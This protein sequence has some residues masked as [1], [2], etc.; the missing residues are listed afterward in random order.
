[1]RRLVLLINSTAKETKQ[2]PAQISEAK[3]PQT[4]TEGNNQ[5]NQV[6]NC[7]KPLQ[8][9]AQLEVLDFT[10]LYNFPFP[11]NP[12]RCFIIQNLS[13]S[14]AFRPGILPAIKSHLQISPIL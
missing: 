10:S 8:V 9:N 11:A 1:M 12:S 2:N 6:K 3:Q 13:I 14:S 5:Q 4:N 7:L